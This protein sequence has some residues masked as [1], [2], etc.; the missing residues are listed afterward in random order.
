MIKSPNDYRKYKY[1]RLKNNLE[2]ILINDCKTQYSYSSLVVGCGNFD[3]MDFKTEGLA[4]S[5]EHM[6]F[7]GNKKYTEPM[8]FMDFISLHSGQTNAYTA[9]DH[10]NYY[11]SVQSNNLDKS[12][13][14]F[15]QFFISPLFT[16]SMIKKEINSV[17]SEH[18]K[19][20][21]D[22]DWRLFELSKKLYNNTPLKNFGTG[23]IHTLDKDNIRDLVISFYNKYYLANNMKLTILSNHS[24]DLLE[25]MCIKYFS[26]IRLND[27]IFERSHQNLLQKNKIIKA[28]PIKNNDRLVVLF[29]LNKFKEFYK[30]PVNNFIAYL[31]ENED[32]LIKVLKDSELIISSDVNYV[33]SIDNHAIFNITFNL[34]NRGFNNQKLIIDLFLSYVKLLNNN[35]DNLANLYREFRFLNAQRFKNMMLPDGESHVMSFSN[36]MCVNNF[37][38]KIELITSDFLFNSFDTQLKELLSSNF[39]SILENYS[40]ISF[41]K[42]YKGQTSLKDEWYKI[43]YEFVDK[44]YNEENLNLTSKLSLPELNT[45]IIKHP[46]ITTDSQD[47]L[48]IKYFENDKILVYKMIDKRYNTPHSILSMQIYLPDMYST[49]ESYAKLLLLLDLIKYLLKPTIQ[50]LENAEYDLIINMDLYFLDIKIIGYPENFINI[51]NIVFGLISNFEIKEI[52]YKLRFKYFKEKILNIMYEEPYKKIHMLLK[53]EYFN[54]YYTH[55][56]LINALDKISYQDM[57]QFSKN[58]F[59]RAQASIFSHGNKID[60]DSVIKIMNNIIKSGIQININD[61]KIIQEKKINKFEQVENK[62]E[63]N[64][65]SAV[66]IPIEYIR[67]GMTKDWAKKM[68]QIDLLEQIMDREYFNELRT[69]QQLGY[70]AYSRSQTDG[71]RRLCFTFIKFLVQSNHKSCEYLV[72]KTMEFIN[73]FDNIL[74][75]ISNTEFDNQKKSL[76]DVLEAPELILIESHNNYMYEI[77]SCENIFDTKK[78]LVKALNKISKE[79]LLEYYKELKNKTNYWIYGIYSE[80]I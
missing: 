9:G 74:N 64:N 69:N 23:N 78:Q 76:R 57:F 39:S 52:I 17:D 32:G 38:P 2:C 15:S 34:T 22:D 27:Q 3:D 63:K 45:F 44:L 14:I 28:I 37:I 55:H 11:F 26:D 65:S 30:Y 21:M 43:D 8:Y 46:K 19:N 71:D 33:N 75:N 4:H 16:E 49:V 42:N 79:D 62:E 13:D 48:P 56:D 68:C 70:I 66:C 72:N 41:S 58:I 77:V 47:K 10:T 40:V 60:I 18:S 67:P 61:L 73:N 24:L 31:L 35:I 80:F 6:V 50:K 5:V 12:L 53:K 1:V 51:L 7:L 59:N 54:K 25:E 20:L 29:E 36:K